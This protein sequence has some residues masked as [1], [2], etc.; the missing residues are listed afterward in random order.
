M[1]IRNIPRAFWQGTNLWITGALD[2]ELG[3][4]QGEDG[5]KV[6]MK[7]LTQGTATHVVAAFD[8]KLDG[9]C[10]STCAPPTVT[11]H[12]PS[13]H[14]GVYL[15]DCQLASEDDLKPYAVDKNSAAKLWQLSE[16]LVGQKFDY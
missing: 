15:V 3:N 5:Y 6:T 9:Q 1:S 10:L 14:N 12:P 8:P 4:K 13:E 2:K 16:E 11:I 7:T